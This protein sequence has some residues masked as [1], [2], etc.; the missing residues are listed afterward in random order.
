MPLSPRSRSAASSTLPTV[1]SSVLPRPA[2][3][4]PLLAAPLHDA[5]GRRR[6]LEL[7]RGREAAEQTLV[8]EGLGLEDVVHRRAGLAVHVQVLDAVRPGRADDL[9]LP[10]AG[11][12]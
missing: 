1:V 3:G 7:E 6:V 11:V 9:A 2:A 8:D 12:V 10:G 5:V 4:R